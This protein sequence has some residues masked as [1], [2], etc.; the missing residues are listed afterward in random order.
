[1]VKVESSA[2]KKSAG[3]IIIQKHGGSKKATAVQK[4]R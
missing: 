3:E 2:K 4:L 1:L